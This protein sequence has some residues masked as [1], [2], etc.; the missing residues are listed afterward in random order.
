MKNEG[1][2]SHPLHYITFDPGSGFNTGD[3]TSNE[4]NYN[5]KTGVIQNSLTKCVLGQD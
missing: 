2:V 3:H 5:A 1:S 4:R